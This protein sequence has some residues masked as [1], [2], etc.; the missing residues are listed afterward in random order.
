MLEDDWE[1]FLAAGERV[2]DEELAEREACL[3]FD[4]ADQHPVHVG[5]DGLPQGRDAHRTTTS[6]TTRTSRRA[7]STTASATAPAC[8]CRS[9]TASA[10]CSGR[11][12]ASRTAR[13]SS[14]R[15]SRSIPVAVLE[16]VEAERCT[17]LCGVPTM[18]IA[19]LEHPAFAR[20]DLS[21]LRTGM[22]GGAPCPVEV[23]KKV[24][25]QMHMDEVDDRLRHDRD[26]AGLDADGARRA[27]SRSRSRR[28][29]ACIRTSR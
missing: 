28:S 27:H 20:F 19:E 26:L 8:P 25:T 29:G 9:T 24:R 13:A 18:F 2:G 6:S 10:W 23:M 14:C 17:S 16:T 12:P 22:M 15:A 21:C 3:Q 5:H 1:E 7:R 11:S 4:D